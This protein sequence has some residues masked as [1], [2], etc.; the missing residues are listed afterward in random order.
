MLAAQFV[1]AAERAGMKPVEINA[2]LKSV[3]EHSAI[4]EFWITGFLR[5]CVF[6]Q[7]WA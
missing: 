3:A 1:A 5:A 2:V 7:Y 6:D 4:E